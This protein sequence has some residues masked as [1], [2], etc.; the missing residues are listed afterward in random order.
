VL[1]TRPTAQGLMLFARLTIEDGSNRDLDSAPRA[2]IS[3]PSH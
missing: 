2:T 1:S 3:H